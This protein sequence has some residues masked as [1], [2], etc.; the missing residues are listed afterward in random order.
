MFLFSNTSQL[1]DGVE[2]LHCRRLQEWDPGISIA[3]K[4]LSR[5]GCQKAA[6]S[7]SPFWHLCSRVKLHDVREKLFDMWGTSSSWQTCSTFGPTSGRTRQGWWGCD[8]FV[9]AS[10]EPR[11]SFP[12]QSKFGLKLYVSLAKLFHVG[13]RTPECARSEPCSINLACSKKPSWTLNISEPQIP[14]LKPSGATNTF[15]KRTT[16]LGTMLSCSTNVRNKRLAPGKLGT[17]MQY[18]RPHTCLKFAA[19]S[20]LLFLPMDHR[21]GCSCV[22]IAN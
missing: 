10:P 14:D 2:P 7:I 5:G 19:S 13:V 11:G 17:T 8:Q 3:V 20:K 18:R 4:C 12:T 9:K 15:E 16:N 21:R 6:C 1:Q 22:G